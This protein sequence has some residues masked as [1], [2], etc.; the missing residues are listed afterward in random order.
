MT[1]Q[2]EQNLHLRYRKLHHPQP[3]RNQ[4]NKQITRNQTFTKINE[5][6]RHARQKRKR[7]LQKEPK[8]TNIFQILIYPP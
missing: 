7:E 5:S 3:N 8:K 6:Y 4:P 2:L 1:I